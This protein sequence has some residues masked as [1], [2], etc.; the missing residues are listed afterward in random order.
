MLAAEGDDELFLCDS[1]S[2]REEFAFSEEEEGT[3]QEDSG[4]GARTEEEEGTEQEDSGDGTQTDEEEGAEGL[5]DEQHVQPRGCAVSWAFPVFAFV[6][7]LD[8]VLNRF[9]GI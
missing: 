2:S 1:N 3:E 8:L 5:E 9:F 7:C 6:L 4:D